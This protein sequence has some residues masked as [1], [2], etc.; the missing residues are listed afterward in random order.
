MSGTITVDTTVT[1][2]SLESVLRDCSWNAFTGRGI[3]SPVTVT[4]RCFS[5]VPGAFDS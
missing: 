2:R 5:T 4:G 3:P 1:G